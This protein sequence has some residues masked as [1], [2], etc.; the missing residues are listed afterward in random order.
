[1]STILS[2][3]LPAAPDPGNNT[4]SQISDTQVSPAQC[5]NAMKDELATLKNKIKQLKKQ[6]TVSYFFLTTLVAIIAASTYANTYISPKDC[7]ATGRGLEMAVVREQA[8]A[9]LHMV[10][11]SGKGYTIRNETVVCELVSERSGEKLDCYNMKK[12]ENQYEISY[13]AT[14]QGRHQLHIKVEGEHIKGS[15]F[16]VTVVKKLVT[17]I[18]IISGVKW[19]EGVAVNQ[20]GEILVAESDTHCVSIFSPT[21]E[22]LGS[23]GS[24][25]SGP[26]QFN[27]PSGVAVVD[28]GN[29]LVVD[30]RNHRIQK[31]TSNNKH[32]TSVGGHGSNLQFVHPINIAISSITKKI[33]V[34]E[35]VNSRI[36]ILNPD[37]T[38]HSSIGSKGSGNGQFDWPRDTA[39]DS[40][41]NLYV[42]DANNHRIQVF[43]PEGQFLRPFETSDGE[44]YFPTGISI[45]SDD[46]VYGRE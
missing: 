17:P 35:L 25:G 31:F 12:M 33:V 40:T 6:V 38:F 4:S 43:N 3:G 24:Q 15:P 21:G 46:T 10:A 22:K 1:M 19:L 34:S 29:I 44:L 16:T 30:T 18:K 5:I 20:K 41:G 42:T 9:V 36:Q 2:N 45:D 11:I 37:L 23:F 8:N 32:I 13:Q 39:F 14:S 26:G 27:E 28:D 7:F